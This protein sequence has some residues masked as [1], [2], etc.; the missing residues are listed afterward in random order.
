MAVWTRDGN[1][2]RQLIGLTVLQ[3]E[4]SDLCPTNASV[5]KG[6]N[7]F[8]VDI[9]PCAR[10]VVQMAHGYCS[11]LHCFTNAAISVMYFCGSSSGI[12]C[13]EQRNST[14]RHDGIA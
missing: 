6:N 10:Q 1:P 8:H 9:L 12:M 2:G 4:N 3:L 13:P 7:G 5:S 14:T 11:K